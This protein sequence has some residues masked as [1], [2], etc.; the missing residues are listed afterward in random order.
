[1]S[2]GTAGGTLPETSENT[3]LSRA[4]AALSDRAA[5]VV[6]DAP[7]PVLVVLLAASVLLKSGMGK[8]PA[9]GA[10]LVILRVLPGKPVLPA[11]YE[12]L[13]SSLAGPIL[14][15][16]LGIR[17]PP[18]FAAMHLVILLIGIAV[19]MAVI[20]AR[21]GGRA[22][23]LVLLALAASQLPAMM[24]WWLGSYDVFTFLL[25]SALVLAQTWPVL[26]VLGIALGLFHFEQGL[27][28]ALGLLALG[29][30]RGLSTG[31][32]AACMLGGLVLGKLALTRYLAAIG[33]R[34]GR[35]TYLLFG[36]QDSG[37]HWDMFID[38]LPMLAYSLLGAAGVWLALVWWRVGASWLQ[39]WRA[40]AVLAVMLVPAIYTHDQTR[41]YAVLSWPILLALTLFVERRAT[42]EEIRML[43]GR[44]LL[45][46]L[47]LPVVFVFQVRS[48]WPL[49]TAALWH[50][51]LL[52]F[53][54][55]LVLAIASPKTYSKATVER[56][57]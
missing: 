43:S 37:S 10:E 44:T 51:L 53:A 35:F 34:Q 23:R 13:M 49:G 14:G 32:R 16:L 25:T 1:M 29:R 45:A 40:V 18:A 8:Y 36:T 52:A 31:K 2:E 11:G 20:R 42:E 9:M 47:V 3:R 56:V 30:R 21:R 46:V 28:V 55:A 41:V 12:F 54:G 57:A 7:V 22:Q 27:F 48:V 19:L 15:R 38:A 26:L 5:S 24:L 50:H 33:M 4:F 17:R 6:L 39:T